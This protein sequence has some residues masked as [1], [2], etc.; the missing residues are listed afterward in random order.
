MHI[1]AASGAPVTLVDGLKVSCGIFLL[2]QP[3]HNI[4][5]AFNVAALETGEKLVC[6]RRGQGYDVVCYKATK[7]V[8][9]H[10]RTSLLNSPKPDG[11][12][13]SAAA[14]WNYE[15]TAKLVGPE[16]RGKTNLMFAAGGHML[17]LSYID[18]KSSRSVDALQRR[19]ATWP[20]AGGDRATRNAANTCRWKAYVSAQA[21]QHPRPR[22]MQSASNRTS[23]TP[24]MADPGGCGRRG[25]VHPWHGLPRRWL[26]GMRPS[27]AAAGRVDGRAPSVEGGWRVWE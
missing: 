26:L 5:R 22:G 15:A 3:L 27:R 19:R 13:A 9:A 1:A 2:E 4:K 23:T 16:K 8:K 24:A 10:G 14:E 7:D 20:G 6:Y 18:N 11:R 25:P 17:L 21:L 12:T